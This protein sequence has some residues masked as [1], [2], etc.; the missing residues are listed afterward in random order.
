MA[1]QLRAAA[2]GSTG[3]GNYGHGLDV[4]F[5]DLEG[6]EFVAVADDHPK[7]LAA[8]GQRTGVTNLYADYRKMLEEVKPDLVS[9]GPR[10]TDQRV[11]MVEAA[12]AVGA[13]IFIEKPLASSLAD[14]DRLL[15]SCKRAG[16]RMAVAHQIRA[17]PPVRKVKANLDAGKY[18]RLLRMRAR[19][20][21]DARGGGED[22]LVLGT[23]LL[24]LMTLFAGRPEWVFARVMEGDRPITL[25][26]AREPS[27]PVGVVA[28]DNLAAA[29]GFPSGV[30]GFIESRKEVTRPGKTPYGLT[31]EC[32]EATIAV[33]SGEAFVYPSSSILPERDLEWEKV[34]VE[35]WHFF[36]DH[37]PRPMEDRFHR[38]NQILVHD[39]IEAVKRNRKPLSS[40]DDARWAM[41]MIQGVYAAHL[42]DK[43]L[44]LPL[45]DRRHPLA[46]P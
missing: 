32:E 37:Q 3:R 8:A 27:E 4:V 34:W 20:K 39:L 42:A 46:I 1:G 36:P 14:A 7:G 13:H 21:E 40:G 2:I 44:S 24:D 15:E 16:V 28:G 33:R 38:A 23:H 17:L 31:L 9:I 10:W 22:L 5:K 43:R 6:V 29:F 26:D 41:E 35:D 25:A 45:Q 18:G 11:E 30:L 12:A 19:G